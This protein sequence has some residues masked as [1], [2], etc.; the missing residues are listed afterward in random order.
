MLT[1]NVRKMT[2]SET[3]LAFVFVVEPLLLRSCAPA[4]DRIPHNGVRSIRSIAAVLIIL[5][6]GGLTRAKL[7]ITRGSSTPKRG[8]S[9]SDN[10]K[11]TTSYPSGHSPPNVR[12]SDSHWLNVVFCPVAIATPSCSLLDNVLFCGCENDRSRNNTGAT[13]PSWEEDVAKLCCLLLLNGNCIWQQRF[14]PQHLVH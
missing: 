5:V 10:R 2:G 13:F 6:I 7:L 8:K 3:G 4:N 14:M 12:R 11:P 1:P 9:T